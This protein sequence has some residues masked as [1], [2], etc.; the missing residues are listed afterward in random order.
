[1]SGQ[2]FDIRER[3]LLNQ[4]PTL[5]VGHFRR[6]EPSIVGIGPAAADLLGRAGRTIQTL[7]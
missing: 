1:M 5:K 4:L 3:L 7:G 6:Q 2:I